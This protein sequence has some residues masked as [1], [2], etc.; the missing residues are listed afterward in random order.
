MNKMST[1]FHMKNQAGFLEGISEPP[2]HSSS[3]IS[4]NS[5][6]HNTS[7]SIFVMSLQHF[8]Y[9]RADS[10]NDFD[11]KDRKEVDVLVDGTTIEVQGELVSSELAG[12]L[13]L[14]SRRFSFIHSEACLISYCG[15]KHFSQVQ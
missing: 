11:G 8:P 2:V 10:W 14:R 15:P 9:D 1:R 3:Y 4:Q 5:R 7:L 6:V 12:M 13:S